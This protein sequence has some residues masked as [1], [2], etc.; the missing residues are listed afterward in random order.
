MLAHAYLFAGSVGAGTEAASLELAK[1]VNCKKGGN[2]ACDECESCAQA[3]RLQHPNIHLIF[4]LPVGKGETAD[5]PP[6][7]KLNAEEFS[8]VRE[9]IRLKAL[10]PYRTISLSRANTIKVSSIREIRRISSISSDQGGKKCFLIFGA[11]DMADTAANAL[12]KTLEEPIGDTLIVLTS[13]DPSKLLPTI[14]CA[15]RW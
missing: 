8:A 3:N 12:L 10:D 5:D 1:T 7:Q 15:V 14:L 11:E 4:P 13:A 6:M 2:E 9:E